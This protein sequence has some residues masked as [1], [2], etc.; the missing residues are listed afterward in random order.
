M[1]VSD[2]DKLK[3]KN[4][5]ETINT[6]FIKKGLEILNSFEINY[7]LSSNP[8]IHTEIALLKICSINK[9]KTEVGIQE[10]PKKKI[11]EKSKVEKNAKIEL[12]VKKDKKKII[13]KDTPNLKN[14]ISSEPVQIKE[15]KEIKY[16]SNNG[17][18]IDFNEESFK[19]KIKIFMEKIKEKKSEIAILK[20]EIKFEGKNVI[21][22][23]DNEL[24]GSIFDDLKNK[25]QFF[26]KETFKENIEVNKEVKIQEKSRTIYTNKD[27]YEYL[28]K[29][30]KSLIDLKNKL[31]LD[32][33]F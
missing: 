2:D 30:N 32:Y 33:E 5:S 8:K 3:F 19:S 13:K 11:S 6:N 17:D 22:Q 28:S 9:K 7:K 15:R 27:K 31:G 21:F 24:E 1:E 16:E 26:L 12:K 4:H 14:L 18:K 29:K 23:L 25:L 10:N 20:K